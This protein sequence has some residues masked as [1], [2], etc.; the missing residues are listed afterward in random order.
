[1]LTLA[2]LLF[3]FSFPAAA[4]ADGQR[5]LAF[6][7]D[8]TFTVMLVADAQDLP[9]VSPY[10]VRSLGGA[11]DDYDVDLVVYL[12]DQLDGGSPLFRIGSAERN[13]RRGI[14]GVLSPVA[15]RGL[16]FAVVFGG[17]DAETGLTAERQLEIYQSYANCLTVDEDPDLPGCGTCALPVRA[18]DGSSVLLNLYLFDSDGAKADGGAV[19]AEQIDWYRASGD[20]LRAENGNTAV[21]SVAFLH[22]VVP[23]VYDALEDA[24]AGADGAFMGE[25]A[26][27]NQYFSKDS[28]DILLGAVNEAPSAAQINNGLFAAF[29]EQ[30]DVFAAFFGNDHLN[31]FLTAQGGV[32]IV[33]V[34]GATYAA[35]NTRLTRG[36]RLVRFNEDN[37]RDYETI[38]VPFSAY[39][40]VSMLGVIP[41]YLTTTTRVSGTAKVL[42]LA[43]VVVLALFLLFFL[44]ARNKRRIPPPYDDGKEDLLGA[45]D[46]ADGESGA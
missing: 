5:Q 18:A 10:F 40:D 14:N 39:E 20:A 43:L 3:M 41:Y 31:T 8:G 12:G 16:P 4:R 19:S 1:M 29:Q 9:Y 2:L 32:D 11:L 7:E 26:H 21:P 17:H 22:T 24:R 33:A 15:G 44:D 35:Y 23:E 13:V 34:P 6:N 45:E 46:G 38:F 36:V 28:A 25:G 27:E 37:V 30:R 42:G